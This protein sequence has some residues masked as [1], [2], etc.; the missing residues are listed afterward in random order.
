MFEIIHMHTQDTYLTQ[1]TII[2][3]NR[4]PLGID[5][6]LVLIMALQARSP[7]RNVFDPPSLRQVLG[8]TFSDSC[9]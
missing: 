5:T 2:R 1:Q 9:G 3:H 4:Y 7:Y 6:M 8:F